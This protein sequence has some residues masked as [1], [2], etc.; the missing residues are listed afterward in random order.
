MTLGGNKMSHD[1][2]IKDILT[3]AI[4]SYG[5]DADEL[6]KFE[7]SAFIFTRVFDKL[8]KKSK[9]DTAALMIILVQGIWRCGAKNLFVEKRKCASVLMNRM[10]RFQAVGQDNRLKELLFHIKCTKKSRTP[11][12]IDLQRIRGD[13]E[14]GVRDES[15]PSEESL[16]LWISSLSGIMAG[17]AGMVRK[18]S[19]CMLAMSEQKKNHKRAFWKWIFWFLAGSAA[20][21]S[22]GVICT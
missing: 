10:K 3:K 14:N 13:V 2:P 18:E 4:E 1:D 22:V 7:L 21:G 20:I 16:S 6:V 11:E 17:L 12:I 19:T 9:R 15:L 8:S 5:K